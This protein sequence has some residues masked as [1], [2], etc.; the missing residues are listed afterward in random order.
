MN[1]KD[2]KIGQKITTGFVS[3][4]LIAVIIGVVGFVSIRSISDYFHEVSEVKF[5]AVRQLTQMETAIESRMV[6]LRTLLDQAIEKDEKER[7]LRG[8]EESREAFDDAYDSFREYELSNESKALVK[9][10]D[11]ATDTWRNSNESFEQTLGELNEM[12]IHY[13]MEFLRNI[14]VFDKEIIDVQMIVAD[15]LQT[16][17]PF[18]GND[19]YRESRL[20]EWVASH[21]TNNNVINTNASGIRDHLR[22]FYNAASDI[23]GH[24]QNGNR[25][26][27]EDVYDNRFMP[28]GEELSNRLELIKDEALL[29]IDL[30]SQME[31]QLMTEGQSD[32]AE[33]RELI[34]QLIETNLNETRESRELGNKALSSAN[35]LL[36]LSIVIGL[37]LAAFLS[38]IITRSITSGINRGVDFADKISQGDL[39][40]NVEE[41][42]LQQKDEIGQ[43]SRGL[44]KMAEQLRAIIG[45]V[46]GSADNIASASLQIS[47]TSQQMSQGASEQASSAEEVSSS[48]EQMVANIQ[49]NTDNAMQTEKIANQAAEAI[50]KGA[51]STDTA[52]KSMKEIANKISIVG[53]IAYQTNMLA[54]NAAVEAARAGEHG[55]G[56]AVVAEEVRKLAERSQIAADEIDGLSERGIKLSDE[57][58]EQLSVI[59]PEIEKT[60]K[61]VQE[62]A[63]ASME[64]NSGADQ[65]NSAIQQLNTVIQ[66]NAAASE[67]M[68]SSS[69]ELSG[70]AEQTKEVVAFFKVDKEMIGRVKRAAKKV[71][72]QNQDKVSNGRTAEQQE[73]NESENK[74]SSS[75]N[76]VDI[77]MDAV[78]D[79]DFERY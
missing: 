8:V 47:S 67:E 53:D 34:G 64:Q 62:I 12:D 15:A 65:V 20:G 32:A 5:P 33:V 10:F 18:E 61:L 9:Q 21:R 23:K 66:Q 59:V 58:S 42:L 29:A 79:D 35:W 39:T 30:N 6:N 73:K 77:K 51:S 24:I 75:G 48:M 13:P 4:S 16:G 46:L 56:F 43:L 37:G 27:A 11:Q 78:S 25:D 68:A 22:Q 38:I 72:K 41:D 54:L 26:A 3:V 63:A 40:S 31:E 2:F 36:L 74:D 57:A 44:Q 71:Q 14:E 76:G 50:K 52:V 69:E 55:K 19:D 7:Q 70:Q 49:Q 45:D 60:A 17:N 28:A 1:F